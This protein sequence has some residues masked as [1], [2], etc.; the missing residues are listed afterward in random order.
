MI[1]NA[2]IAA[3]A[4]SSPLLAEGAPEEAAV[5]ID[6]PVA[7]TKRLVKR[8]GMRPGFLKRPAAAVKPPEEAKP[9]EAASLRAPEAS[10]ART[11][12]RFVR[13]PE[14]SKPAAPK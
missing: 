11:R 13:P 10:G 12:M 9:V 2:L 1:R 6:G 3:L 8:P 14:K 4:L 7:P 5:K